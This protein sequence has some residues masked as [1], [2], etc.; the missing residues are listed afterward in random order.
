M[1]ENFP[2]YQGEEGASIMHRIIRK[3]QRCILYLYNYIPSNKIKCFSFIRPNMGG[4][5]DR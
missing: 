4:G 1:S 3:F 5:G 2:V